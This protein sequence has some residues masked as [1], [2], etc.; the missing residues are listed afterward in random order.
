MMRHN[1][2]L[3]RAIRSFTR[4]TNLALDSD[5]AKTFIAGPNDINIMMYIHYINPFSLRR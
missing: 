5:G 4:A 1:I 3:E 2:N